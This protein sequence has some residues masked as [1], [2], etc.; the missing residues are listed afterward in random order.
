VRCDSQAVARPPVRQRSDQATHD[1]RTFGKEGVESH[2]VEAYL[3]GVL[4]HSIRR[5]GVAFSGTVECTG[6]DVHWTLRGL[7]QDR[8]HGERTDW[9]GRRRND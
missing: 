6:N 9:S 8:P 3:R 5:D 2:D 7:A 4:D 1:N